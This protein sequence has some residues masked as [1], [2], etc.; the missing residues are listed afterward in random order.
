[1][2]LVTVT[3]SDY[4]RLHGAYSVSSTR[5]RSS[6]AKGNVD[7]VVLVHGIGGNFYSSRLLNHFALT[8][9]D[10]GLSTVLINT[11]GHDMVNT[12]SWNGRSRSGGA[13]FENVDECRFDLAAW[14]DFLVERGHGNVLFLGHSLGAIK[15]L[16]SAAHEPPNRLRA[17]IA[18]SPS[19]LS[20][21]RMLETSTDGLFSQTI[22]HCQRLVAEGRGSEPIPVRYP[23]VTWMTPECYVDKYGADEKYNWL[24][25]VDKVEIPALLLFGEKELANHPAFIGLQADLEPVKQNSRSIHIETIAEAD[26]FYSSKFEQVDVCISRWLTQ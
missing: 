7:S 1:M 10:L 8:L 16:Y 22:A 15:S 18:L 21:R 9:R 11:R 17:V 20:Y 13:A 14:H 23:V 5:Q 2:E 3:T 4:V 12:L 19:R 6:I 25:F 26:H 24:N